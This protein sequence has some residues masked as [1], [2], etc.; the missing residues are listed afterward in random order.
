MKALL[1]VLLSLVL[2]TLTAC[3]YQL[4]GSNIHRAVSVNTPNSLY[5]IAI[6][7]NLHEELRLLGFDIDKKQPDIDITDIQFRQYEL[8]GLLT[9]IRIVGT[10]TV[11]YHLPTGDITHTL[12]A[13]RSYQYNQANITSV[14]KHS[15]KVHEWLKQAL[16]KQVSEQYYALITAQNPS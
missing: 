14:D 3:G 15:Q 2:G 11:T 7:Q 10:V 8:I 5:G 13:E 4:R 9:E 16:A 1:T 6:K 12:T